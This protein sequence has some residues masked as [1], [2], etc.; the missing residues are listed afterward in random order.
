MIP[1]PKRP[2]KFKGL[3]TKEAIC[4]IPNNLEWPGTPIA[5]TYRTDK[6]TKEKIAQAVMVWRPTLVDFTD[7]DFNGQPMPERIL[8]DRERLR[9]LSV[10]QLVAQQRARMLKRGSKLYACAFCSASGR[11]DNM[12]RHMQTRCKKY[13]EIETLFARVYWY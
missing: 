1:L 13:S 3:Q 12:K 4:R 2:K 6:K 8:N 9:Y 7:I 5:R 10:Q 11:S